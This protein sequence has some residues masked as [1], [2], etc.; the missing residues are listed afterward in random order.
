MLIENIF[1]QVIVTVAGG[2][3][4]DRLL[5]V[6]KNRTSKNNK[7]D[8]ISRLAKYQTL[9]KNF[10]HIHPFFGKFGRGIRY[11][12]CFLLAFEI[13]N[14]FSSLYWIYIG[15]D[16]CWIY[17]QWIVFEDNS[18]GDCFLSNDCEVYIREEEAPGQLVARQTFDTTLIQ[19]YYPDFTYK[20]PNVIFSNKNKY[21]LVTENRNVNIFN[22]VSGELMN[23]FLVR[24]G[25]VTGAVFLEEDKKLFLVTTKDGD[26][27]VSKFDMDKG[28]FMQE[29][30]WPDTVLI[31]ENDEYDYYFGMNTK[32]WRLFA[33]DFSNLADEPVYD[34]EA[35]L[36]SSG[37]VNSY[38]FDEAG[39]YYV[40]LTATARDISRLEVLECNSGNIL[41][42]MNIYELSDFFFDKQDNLY[43][44]H[45]GKV[46][47][48]N[49]P[50]GQRRTIIDLDAMGQQK[51]KKW[52]GNNRVFVRACMIHDSG[53]LAG[54]VS[55]K[56]G[57][58]CRVYI[59][60]LDAEEITAVSN[61]IGDLGEGGYAQI[62]E[63]KGMLYARIKNDKGNSALR[64]A[65][66]F[67][68]ERKLVFAREPLI[69]RILNLSLNLND[70]IGQIGI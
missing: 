42:Y 3:A 31:G 22:A 33:A 5:A 70:I 64:Y 26:C 46:D 1:V 69:L 11:G 14:I 67:D 4:L 9:Y 23:S 10:C 52:A 60:D 13:L 65:L 62:V 6:Y 50:G 59:F 8:E 18:I 53:Y 57:I 49:L 7:N 41:F 12:A 24:D 16:K 37:N 66:R 34:K 21:L 19:V 43:V 48:I 15:G 27:H 32:E 28:I 55:D 68:E 20:K 44:V 38:F 39:K 40:E 51:E 29:R 58:R 61:P 25:T 47:R 36:L 35:L 17:F 45:Q 56:S 63:I 54:I 30:F 2:F